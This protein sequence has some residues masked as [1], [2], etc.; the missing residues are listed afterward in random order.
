LVLTRIFNDDDA[1]PLTKWAASQRLKWEKE[2]SS[3]KEK[4]PTEEALEAM[5]K[6][7]NCPFKF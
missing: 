1:V 2:G 4:Y 6:V 7:F 5:I 3:L